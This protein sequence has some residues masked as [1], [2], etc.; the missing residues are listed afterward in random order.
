MHKKNKAQVW[1]ETAIYSLIG[2]TIIAILL[3]T[4]MPQ[5]EKMKDK[6][7]VTQTLTALN[8]LDNKII[9]IKQAPGN[10]R[11]IYLKLT[12]GNLNIDSE[13]NKI[14]YTLENT[15]LEISEANDPETEEPTIIE[16]GNIKLRT[17]K[18]GRNF[19]I[20]LTLDYSDMDI[21]YQGADTERILQ[22]GSTDYKL[23]I[24]NPGDDP[25]KAHIDID[26][27]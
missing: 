4:A 27:I 17:D 25:V 9:E 7:V 11:I 24:E 15:K 16:E 1:V 10:V 5:I 18:Y 13:N 14:I 12:K 26:V 20:I 8:E 22:A 6:S 23:K 3:A 2:L 19:N 21:T